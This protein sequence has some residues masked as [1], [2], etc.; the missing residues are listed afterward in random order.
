MKCGELL[1]EF[2]PK[3]I[4]LRTF[5]QTQ[6]ANIKH[7]NVKIYGVD[8]KDSTE[9]MRFF[10]TGLRA[11]FLAD[12]FEWFLDI[13]RLMRSYLDDM[14]TKEWDAQ[15][16]GLGAGLQSGFADEPG[17]APDWKVRIFWEKLH[18]KGSRES[19][20]FGRVPYDHDVESIGGEARIG[21]Q[22]PIAI[23]DN[24]LVIPK[25]GYSLLSMVGDDQLDF[26]HLVS[27]AAEADHRLV[28]HGVYFG[29]GFTSRE[30]KGPL[31]LMLEVT[32]G[33]Y[34]RDDWTCQLGLRINFRSRRAA[35]NHGLL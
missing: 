28:S 20:I 16:I 30:R 14:Y 32:T 9:E 23:G 35:T 6:Q 31:E 19:V 5:H 34:E 8:G 26:N 11:A 7:D 17:L 21:I 33:G 24:F 10:R 22:H 18:Q 27:R 4:S 1:K 2:E 13:Y 29:L 3:G 25:G 12:D 15:G